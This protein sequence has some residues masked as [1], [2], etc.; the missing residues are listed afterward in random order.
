MVHINSQLLME[1]NDQVALHSVAMSTNTALT[2]QY[3]I[4]VSSETFRTVLKLSFKML[5]SNF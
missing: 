1:L 2:E 3:H 5:V 4:V